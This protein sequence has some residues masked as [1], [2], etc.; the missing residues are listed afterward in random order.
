[1]LEATIRW[2]DAARLFLITVGGLLSVGWMG[3]LALLAALAIS[4]V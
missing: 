2:T 1:L 3:F 4:A